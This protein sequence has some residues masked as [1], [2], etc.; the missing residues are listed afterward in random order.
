MSTSN[1]SRFQFK[2]QLQLQEETR[3][4]L[5]NPEDETTNKQTQNA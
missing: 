1:Y 4:Q 5:Y 3:G 2:T